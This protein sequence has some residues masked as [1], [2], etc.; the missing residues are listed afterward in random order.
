ME[1]TIFDAV[2]SMEYYYPE[3]PYDTFPSELPKPLSIQGNHFTIQDF[4]SFALLYKYIYIFF[5][6]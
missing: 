3:F 4:K 1:D 6:F 5:S 2:P